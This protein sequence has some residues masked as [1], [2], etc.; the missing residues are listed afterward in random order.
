MYATVSDLPRSGEWSVECTGGQWIS[1]TPATVGA[2]FR[3]ENHRP[4][5]VVAWAPV[6]RG[7]WTTESEIVEAQPGRVIRW[8]IRDRAGRRQESV[9]SFE[10]RAADDGCVLVH[11]FWM[12]APTEGIQGITAGDGPGAEAGVSQ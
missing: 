6:V 1:G 11:R 12:G 5:N 8:A 7:E 3:G 9:W 2:V 10:L 4:E